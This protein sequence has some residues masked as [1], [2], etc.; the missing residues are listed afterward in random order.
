MPIRD[1]FLPFALPD[2]DHQEAQA[3]GKVI[4]SGW[5]T[6][7]AITAEFERRFADYIGV[8][9]AIAV[10]SA[11]AALHLA[12][13]AIGIQQ[14]DEVITSTFTF[15]ATAEVVR[16]FDAKPVLVDIN[17]DTLNLDPER[18][19][20]AI[21]PRTRAIIP[22]HVA[23][24]SAD[25]YA[26][27]RIAEQH[28]LYIID[29]A[30]HALPTL[31]RGEMIGSIADLTAFSFY[32]TKTLATGEGGMITT[33]ND[34]WADR[35]RVMRLHG[36]SKDAWKRHHKDG[37]WHYEIVAPGFKYNLTDIASAIGLV[38]L[39]K[40]ERMCHGRYAIAQRYNAAFAGHPAFDL[41]IL[42]EGST[43]CYHLY[44]LKL[45]LDRLTINRDQFMVK[46]KEHNI[47]ASVHWIPLHLHPYY[48]ERYGYQPHDFP[49]A[50]REGLRV[51]SLPIYSKM[52]E[53]DIE[54]VIT[55]TLSIAEQYQ[56]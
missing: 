35:C 44:V 51:L 34:E 41:P 5:I 50:S 56:R 16:Y 18:V 23:G 52:S 53:T 2:M 46:L 32:A 21:T 4:T 42:Q 39:G 1:T 3:A 27:K 36:I 55:A 19:A 54:D 26:I 9:H 40:L 49:H 48:R 45:N 30:A 37:S 43:H 38:Q 47:G 33:N 15:A 12:L 17:P 11:T 7:G 29:D 13:E 31:Y 6:T 8:K 25:M 22:V 10:N 24:Q 14:G 20:A 28:N